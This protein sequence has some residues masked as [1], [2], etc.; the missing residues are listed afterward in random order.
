MRCLAKGSFWG[1]MEKDFRR[2]SEGSLFG[3]A[4]N[5]SKSSLKEREREEKRRE[6]REEI[7]AI[8]HH[9]FLSSLFFLSFPLFLPSRARITRDSANT[10]GFGGEVG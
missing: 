4:F 5:F 1:V 9:E 2:V 6:G 8:I 3:V 10:L 7:L